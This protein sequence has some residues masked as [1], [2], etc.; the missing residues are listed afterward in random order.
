[1]TI[2]EEGARKVTQRKGKDITE[3]GRG[4]EGRREGN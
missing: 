2:E 3:E 1:M 4:A